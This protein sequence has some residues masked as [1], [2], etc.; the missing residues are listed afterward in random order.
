VGLYGPQPIYSKW[1]LRFGLMGFLGPDLV[2]LSR[3]CL[4]DVLQIHLV[5]PRVFISIYLVIYSFYLVFI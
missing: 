1:D 5:F 2:M 4:T 3:A